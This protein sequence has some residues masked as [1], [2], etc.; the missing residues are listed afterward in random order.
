MF[1]KKIIKK[2]MDL[3]A[4]GLGILF[5]LPFFVLIALFIKLGSKGPVFFKQERLGKGGKV[6]KIIKF[7]TMVVNAE[8]IGEGLRVS[9]T[10]DP[11]ITKVGNFLRK[12]SLDELPQLFNVFG[13]SMSLVGPR[14]PATYHPY[15]FEEYDET[16]KKR[17]LVKPGITG[18]AQVTVRNSASWDDR[19]ALDIQYIEKLTLFE[20]IKI[21]FKTVA[22]V[23]KKD[24][25]YGANTNSEESSKEILPQLD[26]EVILKP[27]TKEDIPLKVS[28]VNDNENN[29][30]L[31][32]DIPL[33]IEGTE[34]WW[35]GIKDRQDRKDFII[36]YND[37]PVG[38]TGLLNI[39]YK[40][41]N[42]E[43]HI[44]LGD[45][46]YKNKGIA[47]KA[48]RL[49]LSYAFDSLSLERVYLFVEE[50][51]IAAINL[52]KK[53]HFINEGCLRRHIVRNEKYCN[54]LIWG[55]LKGE[56]L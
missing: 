37:I 48:L 45:K 42:S 12:T 30:F 50:D 24:S 15:K 23:L 7:R 38:L 25:I 33:T 2:L 29:E 3:L 9:S 47:T 43:L 35:E 32:Y 44:I 5:L 51:N 54:Y 41:K 8:N 40:N 4:S 17:F 13:G 49:L 18:L 20:D 46:S 19:I 16:Q 10:N 1:Y 11:R 14:P 53:M 27:F 55:I 26:G 36:Y 6:F 22:K 28:W 21:L 31:H 52:Y 39:N 56:F 34:K